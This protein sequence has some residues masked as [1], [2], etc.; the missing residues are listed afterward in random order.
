MLHWLLTTKASSI[1]PQSTWRPSHMPLLACASFAPALGLL[2]H[3]F[4]PAAPSAPGLH[5]P[6]HPP[7][8]QSEWLF[9]IVFY[10]IAHFLYMLDSP[11]SISSWGQGLFLI[12]LCC[13]LSRRSCPCFLYWPHRSPFCHCLRVL[14]LCFS[15]AYPNHKS[16]WPLLINLDVA[17][18]NVCHDSSPVTR[19]VILFVTQTTWSTAISV[20]CTREGK[21]SYTKALARYSYL[22]DKP[23]YTEHKLG[24][25]RWISSKTAWGSSVNPVKSRELSS[26]PKTS[27]PKTSF[28]S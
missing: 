12:A 17:S 3:T 19:S 8:S 7:G 22:A 16:A 27:H 26:L 15:D 5:C 24:F 11:F 9:C 4:A 14:H 18:M 2:C 10:L 1:R 28:F 21:A 13:L 6:L 20:L 23:K 25:M